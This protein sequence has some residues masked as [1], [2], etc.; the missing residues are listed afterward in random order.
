MT[1]ACSAPCWTWTTAWRHASRFTSSASDRAERAWSRSLRWED[2]GRGTGSSDMRCIKEILIRQMTNGFFFKKK[3]K[4]SNFSTVTQDDHQAFHTGHFTSETRFTRGRH[5]RSR[6][7]LVS[8]VV[9]VSAGPLARLDSRAPQPARCSARVSQTMLNHGQAREPLSCPRRYR[10][11][12][13][14]CCWAHL[15]RRELQPREPSRVS[16]PLRLL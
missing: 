12:W 4:K 10:D 11:T 14:G 16:T 1:R 3:T 15:G 8:A 2:M 9:P 5:V 7:P 13:R 6:R